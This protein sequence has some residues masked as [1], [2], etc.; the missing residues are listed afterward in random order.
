M[1]DLLSGGRL[2]LRIGRGYQ[3]VEFENFGLDLAEARDRFDESRRAG[4]PASAARWSVRARTE[5]FIGSDRLST[6]P[7]L[8]DEATAR[9]TSG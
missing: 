9:T 3:A 6:R 7:S 2:E 1:V 4:V 8:T 5:P